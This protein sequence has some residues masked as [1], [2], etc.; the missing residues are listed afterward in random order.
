MSLK[1]LGWNAFLEACWQE[2]RDSG[3]TAARVISQQRGL[4][5]VAGDFAESW[6]APSGK[7][8]EEADAGGLWPAVGDWVAADLP[9][10]SL[11]KAGAAYNATT[12]KQD[13]RA[14]VHRVL[15]R[16]GRFARKVAGQR[17]EEQVI[18]ANV[19]AAFVL[20]G[21]GSDFN[22]RR[23]ERYL[24]QCW[25]AGAKLVMVLNKV[26]QCGDAASCVA[27]AQ[28]IAMGVPV[29]A[30]SA[31]TGQG[32][33]NLN[34][35]LIAGQTVVLLGSS[36]VGK[37]TLLNRLLGRPAQEVHAVRQS[38][39][40]GRHTTTSRELFALANGALMIDTPGLR[41]LHL[42][43]AA[44]GVAQTFGDIDELAGGCRFRDCTHSG[45]PG[46]AVQAAIAAG[47]LDVERL[48]NRRK[49]EREQEFLQRKIDPEAREEEKQ[50]IRVLHRRAKQIYEQRQRDGG[51]R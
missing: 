43:D 38:D 11:V 32:V 35:F 9:G 45:E 42:W 7:L 25:E 12:K 3:C 6:A 37:S 27:E 20:A 16:R 14:I 34:G 39:G 29:V 26:D 50:R 21:L 41:E 13:E 31:L 1:G 33:E 46:C 10:A 49:L 17:A 18:A 24:A 4:W 22:L 36:G 28:R 51:K 8:R 40:R 48:E 15:P 5:R 30:V 2:H 44:E 19:D 23:I 47:E